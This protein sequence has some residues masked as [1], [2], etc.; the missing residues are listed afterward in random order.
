VG[1]ESWSPKESGLMA[2]NDFG[3]ASRSNSA[4]INSEDFGL[5]VPAVVRGR[6]TAMD[7]TNATPILKEPRKKAFNA[8]YVLLAA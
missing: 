7:V 1:V 5:S 6:F 3:N 8:T 4:K 2:P